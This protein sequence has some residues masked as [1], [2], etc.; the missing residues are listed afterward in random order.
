MFWFL[1]TE[2]ETLGN[3]LK[4]VIFFKADTYRSN[5]IILEFL[6]EVCKKIM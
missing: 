2:I 4:M 5:T 6:S 3:Y 1:N